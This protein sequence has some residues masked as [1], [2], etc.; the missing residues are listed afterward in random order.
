MRDPYTVLGVAKSAS[1]SEIKSAFRKLAKK[2][3]PDTN[4]DDPKAKERFSEISRANEIVGDPETRKKFDR[5][6]IDAEGKETFGAYPGGNPFT[7]FD[8]FDPRAGARRSQ[9]GGGGG[10]MNPEDILNTMFGGGLGSM[11]RGGQGGGSPFD[12]MFGDRPGGQPRQAQPS[13]GKD[14]ELP[15]HISVEQAIKGGKAKLSLP[16]GRTIAVNV[17]DYVEEGQTIR[18]K[19]QGAAGPAGHRGDVLAKVSIK[20][21]DDAMRVEGRKLIVDFDVPLGV[22]V[23]GGKVALTTPDGKIAVKIEP[24]TDSGHAMR[25]K[26]RGLPLKKGGRADLVAIIRIKLDDDHKSALER[27][28]ETD[29][30]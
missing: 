15:L 5:G 28:F 23:T 17:P 18:L 3:H 6:E 21:N 24:W 13:K 29:Q 9:R 16:D 20:P 7:G 4:R 1:D 12:Q 22:A 11:G 14:I 30:G 27:L 19:G 26:G 2:Y 8:G 25:I 10:G